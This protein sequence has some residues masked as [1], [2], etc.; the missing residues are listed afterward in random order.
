VAA[1]TAQDV[2]FDFGDPVARW[3]ATEAFRITDTA[4]L[5]GQTGEM[6]YRHGIPIYRIGY[7]QRTLHPEFIGYG[8]FW[9]RGGQV[10]VARAPTSIERDDSYLDN[11]LP[12]VFEQAKTVRVRLEQV[13]SVSFP[14]LRQLKEEGA[15]DYVALPVIFSDGRID[16][17]SVSSDKPGG[18]S[19][20]DLDRLFG[21]QFLFARITEIHNLRTT[22]VNLLD[23]YVGH[24]AGERILDGVIH[25]GDGESVQAALWY[26]DLRGF[27]T[28]S[29]RLPRDQI[30][31]LLN[32]Y[33]DV[34]AA[35]V[36]ARGGDIVKFIGDAMLAI[37]RAEEPSDTPEV[38][39]RAIDA[40]QE[41]VTQMAALNEA[42]RAEGQDT[43]DFGLALHFGEVMFGN[44]GAPSRL[45]FTVVGPAVNL[46]TRIES[47]CP[48][49]GSRVLLSAD[50]ARHGGE[51]VKRR[52]DFTVKGLDRPIDVFE[53]A[54]LAGGDPASGAVS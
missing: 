27:T 17:L 34:M 28:L 12:Q 6:L 51:R 36:E 7:I 52:G 30:I 54:A 3:F 23:T 39:R 8:Y 19:G 25:R 49:L 42:R 4:D 18:F 14:L 53:L 22:A 41:A 26:C 21:L 38:C 40:A 37:F 16:G 24:T 47:L 43:I 31:D 9:R 48:T 33:F 35:P 45:D 46:V 11:P 10:E 13:E 1:G 50:V 5:L 32:A 2:R 20:E 29:D 15:T 44:I